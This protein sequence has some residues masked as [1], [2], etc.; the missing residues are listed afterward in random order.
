MPPP[1]TPK[2]GDVKITRENEDGSSIELYWSLD[3]SFVVTHVS[4]HGFCSRPAA[5]ELGGLAAM[6]HSLKPLKKITAEVVG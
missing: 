6:L 2:P 1:Y 4:P 3:G 5:A